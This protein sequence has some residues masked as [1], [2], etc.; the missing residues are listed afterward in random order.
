[1]ANQVNLEATL[2]A[3]EAHPDHWDQNKWHCGTS[4]CIAGFAEMLRL[5]LSPT[6]ACP[7]IDAEANQLAERKATRDWLGVSEDEW[8]VLTDNDTTLAMLREWTKEGIPDVQPNY[9]HWDDDDDF[10]DD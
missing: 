2:A 5:G 4:H 1:M 7:L 8:D 9:D 10:C 6:E 3:I